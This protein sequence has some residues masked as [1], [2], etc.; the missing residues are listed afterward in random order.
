MFNDDDEIRDEASEML[1]RELT[2]AEWDRA[3]PLA[4]AKLERII[5]RE[6]DANGERNEP[7]YIGM[8][9][10]EIARSRQVQNY[11]FERINLLGGYGNETA[12]AYA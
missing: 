6:G 9:V 7:Y 1:G 11:C 3:F 8:L 10:S 5:E 2:D 12:K 4:K